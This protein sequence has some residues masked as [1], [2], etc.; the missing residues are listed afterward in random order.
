M[1]LSV[2]ICTW[3]RHHMLA[4]TLEHMASCMHVPPGMKWEVLVVNNNCTD[5]TDEVLDHFQGRLPVRRLFELSPGLSAARNCALKAARGPY[6]V[7][8]DDDVRPEATWLSAYLGAFRRH[9]GAAFFGG[10]V[11]PRFDVAPPAWLVDAWPLVQNAYAVCD[12]GQEEH[13]LKEDRLPFGANMAF[14]VDMLKRFSFDQALGNAGRERVGGEETAV[15]KQMLAAGASG[16][17]VPD[18]AVGHMIPQERCTFEYLRNYY[19]GRGMRLYIE[20]GDER[21]GMRSSAFWRYRQLAGSL[22]IG[23]G[24]VARIPTLRIRGLRTASIARGYFARTAKRIPQPPA[25]TKG[26]APA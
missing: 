5:E 8:T 3:N 12:L 17:W 11:R 24:T 9:P 13:A 18:A 25:A 7:W 2:A 10:P 21:P 1:D 16:Y 23:I 4:E 26:A 14:R 20:N 19:F 6:I 22:A 15:M